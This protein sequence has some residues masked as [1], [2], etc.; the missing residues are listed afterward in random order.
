MQLLSERLWWT[1]GHWSKQDA[2]EWWCGWLK[3]SRERAKFPCWVKYPFNLSASLAT[4]SPD[5]L[6]L[7][8]A[9]AGSQSQVRGLFFS[10]LR[11]EGT[12][13]ASPLTQ[14]PAKCCGRQ[15]LR[16][17][18]HLLVTQSLLFFSLSAAKQQSCNALSSAVCEAFHLDAKNTSR[19]LPLK[20]PG[21]SESFLQLCPSS[22]GPVGGGVRVGEGV[23]GVAWTSLETHAWL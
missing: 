17:V 23:E 3:T 21:V 7:D 15:P 6:K 8:A 12:R 13:T 16:L 9:R 2:A 19:C 22:R 11:G 14:P 1:V 5:L 4:A 10:S 18:K 20:V